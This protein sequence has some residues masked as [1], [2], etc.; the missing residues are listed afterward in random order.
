MYVATEQQQQQQPVLFIKYRRRAR[1][2]VNSRAFHFGHGENR[3]ATATYIRND[4]PRRGGE[5]VRRDVAAATSFSIFIWL[6]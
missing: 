6:V 2:R 5:R 1:S 4:T 3:R